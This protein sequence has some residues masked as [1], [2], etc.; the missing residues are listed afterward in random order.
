MN[1]TQA[2]IQLLKD[3]LGEESWMNLNRLLIVLIPTV[4]DVGNANA[5][6]AGVPGYIANKLA[7]ART[8]DAGAYRAK[9][10]KTYKELLEALEWVSRRITND[11]FHKQ[12]D[13][14]S[15]LVLRCALVPAVIPARPGGVLSKHYKLV[16]NDCF[17]GYLGHPRHRD[18]K[19]IGNWE[20]IGFSALLRPGEQL[21]FRA[22][23]EGSCT[24]LSK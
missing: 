14:R 12:D 17:E 18:M 4:E 9:T 11:S 6:S 16:R 15:E 5:V 3:E 8:A 13:S 19:G 22:A 21:P 24:E 23:F 10:L 1:D 2:N 7:R 20:A